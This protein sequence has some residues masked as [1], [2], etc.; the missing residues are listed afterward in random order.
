[1]KSSGNMDKVFLDSDIILDFILN[2]EPFSNYASDILSLGESGKIKL[3]SSGLVFSNCYYILR[4]FTSHQKVIETLKSLA[5]L[6]DFVA[7]NRQV[8]LDALH[9]SF[10]DFEDSIQNA[11]AAS[12][13]ITVLLT[14][15]TK[16][17]K[18]SELSIMT[19]EAYL[20]SYI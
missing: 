10:K 9:A 1:M 12:A 16:D 8:V 6:M 5:L 2:R 7:I 18:Q 11:S 14:R 15:N 17:Y 20:A 3:Y 4:K 19:P 13:G